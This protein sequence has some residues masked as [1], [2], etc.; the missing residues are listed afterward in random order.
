[1]RIVVPEFLTSVG[2]KGDY[3]VVWR[4][5]IEDIVHHE[6]C[7]FKRRWCSVIPRHRHFTGFPLPGD[8]ELAEIRLIDLGQSRVMGIALVTAIGVPFSLRRLGRRAS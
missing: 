7:R 5:K 2:I 4:W 6:W 3:A 1:M 8:L